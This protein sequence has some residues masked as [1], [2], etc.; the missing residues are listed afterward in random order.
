[1]AYSLVWRHDPRFLGSD[2]HSSGTDDSGGDGG[3]RGTLGREAVVRQKTD[4]KTKMNQ[5]ECI[6]APETKPRT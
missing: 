5:S 3:L 6:T 1:M 4:L 2:E